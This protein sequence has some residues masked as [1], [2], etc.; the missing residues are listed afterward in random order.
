MASTQNKG[1]SK[2][3][4]SKPEQQPVTDQKTTAALEEDD[5]FE[6]FPVD[7]TII[8]MNLSYRW[9]DVSAVSFR[10][11]LDARKALKR[12]NPFSQ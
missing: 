9:K 10:E 4:E 2:T 8:I 11:Q 1:D 5:E 6:D 12:P 3:P 7:G